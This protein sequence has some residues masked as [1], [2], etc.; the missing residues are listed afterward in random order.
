YRSLPTRAVSDSPHDEYA[1]VFAEAG[2]T[3]LL[4]LALAMGL[5]YT[6]VIR[7]L[8]TR[9]N[10]YARGFLAGGLGALL[11]VSFHSI[12]DFPM[13][14]PAIAAT[15]AVTAALLWRAARIESNSSK[16]SGHRPEGN[17][18]NTPEV[19]DVPMA[20][21]VN[22]GTQRD[23]HQAR[24]NR[25]ALERLQRGLV[26]LVGVGIVWVLAGG[27]ALDPLR[28]QLEGRLIRRAREHVGWNA[29]STLAL[30]EAS[31][32]SLR[33]HSAG[34]ARL[35]A[36]LAD[37]ADAAAEAVTDPVRRLELADKSL[38]LRMAA[39]RA[40]PLNAWHP[41]HAAVHYMT[42]QRPDL[43][44]AQAQRACR[45]LPNDPWVRAYLAD[46]FRAYVGPEAARPYLEEAERLAETRLIE[47]AK[48]LIAQVRKR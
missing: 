31:E 29:D 18:E 13:R 3:G 38:A 33:R 15:V 32:R 6:T 37:L 20:G 2:V 22:V 26:A 19:R 17:P 5:L 40:E 21:G 24:E 47:T 27:L 23:L 8:A 43:A 42:F 45:L 46:A 14:S 36:E 39:A 7:G 11:M 1:H 12:V 48:P 35:H 44:W 9:R 4:I 41:F 30:V 25:L 34:D 10:P 28:G 16:S